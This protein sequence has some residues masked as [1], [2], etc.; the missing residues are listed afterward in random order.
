MP[1]FF[2]DLIERTIATY[3]TAFLGLLLADGFDL[4]SLSALKVAAIAALPAALTVL[5]GA[6]GS[7][8]GSPRTAAWLPA[9]KDPSASAAG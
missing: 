7:W 1:R 2:L 6:I 9:D 5:K 8:I 4:T 3:A